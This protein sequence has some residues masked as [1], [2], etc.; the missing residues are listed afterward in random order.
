MLGDLMW[1]RLPETR[2]F[3]AERIAS[4]VEDAIDQDD[5]LMLLVGDIVTGALWHPVIRPTLAAYPRSRD[6]LAA[7]LRVVRE[8]YLAEHPDQGATRGMLAD[9]VFYNLQEP[10]YLAIVKEVDPE[11]AALINSVMGS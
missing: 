4:A 2:P 3:L 10:R 1:M 5:E 7:Q 9:Y 8:A 6:R 11:L